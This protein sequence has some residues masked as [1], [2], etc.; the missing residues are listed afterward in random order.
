[1]RST[2]PLSLAVVVLAVG[3]SSVVDAAPVTRAAK[4]AKRPVLARAVV[5]DVPPPPFSADT[6][7]EPLEPR[8]GEVAKPT[9]APWANALSPVLVKN[10]NTNASAKVRLYDDEGRV[11][12]E[13]A[14]TFMRVAATEKDKDEPLPPRLVQ[15][16]VRASYHFNGAPIVVLSATRAGA[17]GK[18][19]TGE[20]LD[21]SLEGVK[22]GVLASYLFSLPRVGV[23]IYTHPKT[24][25]VHL[26][27]R[28]RSTHWLDA[29]PPKVTWREKLLP[30]PKAAARD[31]TYAPSSDLPEVA[32]AAPSSAVA[33]R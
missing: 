17:K 3:T 24:Q 7:L 1:M 5:R 9:A 32:T 11:D 33:A 13:A 18:H 12:E 27:V 14:R 15:L 26:D 8:R 20:A 29:S 21:F 10:R 31:A 30:D 25:F 4:P 22:A 28:D 2:A 6:L 19:G 16:A 23:G